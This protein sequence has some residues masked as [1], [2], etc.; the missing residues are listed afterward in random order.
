MRRVFALCGFSLIATVVA[1]AQ[2][3]RGTITGTVSDPAGA[4]VASA[5]IQAKNVQTGAIYETASTTTGNYTI[6]QLPAGTYALSVSVQGFKKYVRE[7]L[8]V[9]VAQIARID[10]SLEV[11][12]NSESVTVTEAAPLLSTE[13][14]ELSHNVSAQTLDELPVL[15]VGANFAGTQGVRNPNAVLVMIPGTYWVPNN[16]VRV[17]GAPTN[18]QAFRVEGQD[19]TDGGT[20]GVPAQLQPSVDA[21]QEIAVQTSNY[22]AEYGQ[23]GGGVFNVTMKSGTNQFHGT[24]YEYLVNE[25]LNAGTPFLDLPAGSGNPRPRQRRYDYGF[26]VGGPVWIPKL[27]NGRNKTFF[28]FSFE[29]FQEHQQ[30]NNLI[31]TVPTAA[32]RTGDFSA[33]ITTGKALTTDPLGRPV[34]EGE[35]FDPNTTRNVTVSGVVS[36]V[37][38][39]FPGNIILPAR[40]DP[41]AVKIQSYIPA[42]I[43]SNATGIANNYIPSFTGITTTQIPSIKM[44]QG[45]GSKGKLSF[46][47]S[48]NALFQPISTAFGGGA[49]GLP[50]PI[51]TAVGSIVPTWVTRLNYDHS[52]TPTILLHVGAGYQY[53]DFGIKSVTADGSGF[54]NFDSG[55]TLGLPGTI[56]RFFPSISGLMTT[57]PSNGGMKAMGSSFD[58]HSYT[59]KPTF[60]L[61]LAWVKS[62]HSAKF[63]AEVRLEGYP[64]I[65]TGSVNGSYAFSTATTSE[66]YL[67]TTTIAGGVPGFGYASFLLGLV[68]SGNI[69]YPVELRQGKNQTGVYAQDSWKVT[70]KLTLDYGLRYDY[71]TYLKEQ[72]G[73]ASVFSPTVPNPSAGNLPGAVMFEGSGPGHCGCQ[74]AHN[75]PWGFA[76]RLGVAYQITSK[77]VF[78]GGFGIVYAGTADN[79]NSAGGFGLSNPF[80]TPSF[81][82]P[83]MQ[84]STGIPPAFAPRPFPTISAGIYPFSNSIPNSNP[85]GG[86]DPNAGRPPRQYQWSAGFQ[87]EI[88][89]DLA[90]EVSYVGNRGIWWLAPGLI[91]VNAI[92]YSRLQAA[93]L[94]INNP[95]DLSLLLQ[96]IGSAAAAARGLGVPYAGYPTSLTV[97]Q[98][99]RPFPQFGTINYYWDPLGDTW[100]NSL[101]AKATK[102]FS[103]G[104]SF[105]STFTWAKN[106][107]SG[108]ETVPNPGTTGGASVNDVFNRPNNKYISQFDTPFAW[109]ASVNYTTPNLKTNKIVSWVA[110]DWTYGLFLQYKSG[111]PMLVPASNNNLASDLFQTTFANRVPGQ[112]LFLQN[113]NCHCFDPQT[114]LVLN[115]NAWADPP[116][117]QFGTSAAYYTDYRRQRHPIENMNLGRTWRIKERA[118]FN[119]RIEFSNVFN[120]S[121]FSDPASTNAKAAVTRAS[122]GNITGGFGSI[123][124]TG[125]I[126]A[127]GLNLQPRAGTLIGRL[128]F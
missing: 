92:S 14:G 56:N 66:P 58:S 123:S 89:K 10:V 99:L 60:N 32:Y 106:E 119:L 116:A 98:A 73:R 3:D 95:T 77:T 114:T 128:S 120:R 105:L 126:A 43:G 84:L 11:G 50:D 29:R 102:R 12:S 5:A 113:L 64:A 74:F 6:P 45:I 101:Q 49:D 71:S 26:T 93:G 36:S 28:F 76:P 104:I 41:V 35:I 47:F 4:V 110:R 69:A 86:I 7:G 91:N 8:G 127:S 78:R 81:G 103:H 17:N 31:E 20:P 61:S 70:R 40:F 115:P 87:R 62:N 44:D 82:V 54:T 53:V 90:V 125:T 75:Y 24:A 38:D 79:N 83:V 121:V 19:A 21:I 18:T 48:R 107:T 46:Y 37:R 72:Y 85:P 108:A 1:I 96:P 42:G 9:Q 111:L 117:G 118:S 15:G 109:N 65:G 27:Y 100:Y 30:V 97:A 67:Q 25:A 112:P 33:A 51:T 57:V 16:G 13:S 122:N 22:A 2:S 94:N 63:G 59:E 39:P 124:A 88:F 80:A 52:L 68:N 55:A 34:M 23:V